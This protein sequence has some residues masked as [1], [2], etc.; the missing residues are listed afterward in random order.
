ASDAA[1]A[2][3]ALSGWLLIAVALVQC[4]I[5]LAAWRRRELIDP[6]RLGLGSS[7][8]RWF[9]LGPVVCYLA[10][11]ALGPDRHGR[12][13]FRAGVGLWYTLMLVPVV[14]PEVL[15]GRW[16]AW[17]AWHPLRRLARAA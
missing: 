6:R 5:A 13:L 1:R 15:A 7:Y 2:H 9:L 16:C 8:W 17:A 4:R 11:L 12:Y 14:M 3:R 10:M